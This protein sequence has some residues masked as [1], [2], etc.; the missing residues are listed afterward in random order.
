MHIYRNDFQNA[1]KHT[2]TPNTHPIKSTPSHLVPLNTAQNSVMYAR[3]Q[4]RKLVR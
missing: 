4:G 1:P 2:M 3:I